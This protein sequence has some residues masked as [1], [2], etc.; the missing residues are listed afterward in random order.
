MCVHHVSV[1]LH[2][3]Q[4]DNIRHVCVSSLQT[5]VS[6]PETEIHTPPCKQEGGYVSRHAGLSPLGNR[7]GFP[8]TRRP[9]SAS[10]LTDEHTRCC[11]IHRCDAA[12]IKLTSRRRKISYLCLQTSSRGSNKHTRA[13]KSLKLYPV[14]F[15]IQIL[16]SCKYVV[17]QQQHKPC[18]SKGKCHTN[19]REKKP[20]EHQTGYRFISEP[21]NQPRRRTSGSTG[22]H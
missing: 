7:A 6:N 18:D 4:A 12:V 20:P 13:T 5:P 19:T 17:C 1:F 22:K 14:W 15:E 11:F 2:V 8:S 3:L 16:W 9:S 21:I 10:R